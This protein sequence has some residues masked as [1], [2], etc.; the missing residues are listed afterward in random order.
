MEQDLMDTDQ[1]G[2]GHEL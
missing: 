1:M 2:E